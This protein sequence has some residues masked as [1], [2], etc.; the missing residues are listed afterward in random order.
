MNQ[1]PAIYDK[2]HITTDCIIVNQCAVNDSLSVRQNGTDTQFYSFAERGIGRSRNT[3]LMRASADVCLF[4]DD[5]VIYSP[6]YEE[7]VLREFE[8]NEKADVIIF[9]VKSTNIARPGNEIRDRRRVRSFNC[10]RYCAFQIAVRRERVWEKNIWFSLLFGGGAR[11]SCGED[12]LF[13]WD[14]VRRHLRVYTS[15][16]TIGVVTHGQSSWFSGFNEKYFLDKGYF[17]KTLSAPLSFL[18]CVHYLIK[19]RAEY[20]VHTPLFKAWSLMHRGMN[21]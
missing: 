17:Y 20:S 21:C 19:N 12:S 6:G 14:C 10:L 18:F 2:M 4:A 5:D 16:A 1:T 13:L 11:Y 3:A 9:N 7:T 15:P 8:Q